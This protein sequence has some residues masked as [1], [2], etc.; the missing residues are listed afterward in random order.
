[1]A[2]PGPDE[3]NPADVPTD[4]D[5]LRQQ[6]DKLSAIF[7]QGV[8]STRPA[9]SVS[10]RFFFATDENTL[11]YDDGATWRTPGPVGRG[12]TLP[13]TPFDGQEYDY[14]ADATNGVVWRFR[15]R[16]ASASAHKWESVG[17]AALWAEI[18]TA[19]STGSTTY[20]DLTTVG[21]SLTVPLAGDYDVEV[22]CAVGVY[23]AGSTKGTSF[24]GYAIGAVAAVDEDAAT[25]SMVTEAGTWHTAQSRRKTNLGAGI[26]LRAKYRITQY[27][28]TWSQRIMRLSPVRVG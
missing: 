18:A 1:M 3:H 10:G 21:P 27:S 26:E 14:V 23:S 4:I 20:V 13:A 19:Q 7:L 17:G 22:A 9:A 8:I 2:L 11:Y 16:A 6:I 12:T 25:L 5:K 24:M 28:A 15:Y